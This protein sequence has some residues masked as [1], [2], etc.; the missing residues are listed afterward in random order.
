MFRVVTLPAGAGDALVVEWGPRGRVHRLLVDAGPRATWPE[1]GRLLRARRNERYDLLVVTHIDEDHVGG[2]VA[3]LDDAQ[4]NPRV[5]G[6]WFNGFAHCAAADN[7]LGPV[8]GEQ[9]TQRIFTARLPWNDGWR[10][11][12]ARG[13]GGP[14]VVPATGALPVVE[15]AEGARLVLLG[16]LP[17]QLTALVPGWRATVEKAGLVPGQ[18]TDGTG[19]PV[20]QR[21]GRWPPLPDRLDADALTRIASVKRTDGSRAN[22]SSIAFV[23]EYDGLRVLLPGDAHGAPLAAGVA[24]YG[25]MVGQERP[26]FDLV[27]LPHHGSAANTPTALAG[28]WEASRFLV[29]S[30]GSGYDH[31][32]DATL[33][34]LLLAAQGAPITVYGNHAGGGLARWAGRA[35]ELPLTVETPAKAGGITVAVQAPRRRTP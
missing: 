21:P 3:L 11:P 9:L 23:L 13:C 22:A 7:V 28:A 18:G 34:R 32:D 26:R 20:R 6:V 15:L 16:P 2:A 17:G 19:R 31:P 5:D 12:I 27:K 35:A 24:R 14:V 1:V 30:D 8:H 29:S 4:L 10:R 25:A 33:A